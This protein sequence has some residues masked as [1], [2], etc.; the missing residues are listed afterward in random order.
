MTKPAADHIC[1]DADPLCAAQSRKHNRMIGH[2][3]KSHHA[4]ACLFQILIGRNSS[5]ARKTSTRPQFLAPGGSGKQA[6]KETQDHT[7]RDRQYRLRRRP[8]DELIR[9]SPPWTMRSTLTS[10]IPP[11]PRLPPLRPSFT[12]V[13]SSSSTWSLAR[14]C[15][16]LDRLRRDEV[17]QRTR[18]ALLKGCF[19][20]IALTFRFNTRV[21]RRRL[22]RNC[23]IAF[24]QA[25][26][27]WWGADR[28][29][30]I[31]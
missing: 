8:E 10:I 27:R 25:Q 17:C 24:P 1:L 26:R 22:I 3:A 31:V 2:L 29:R 21:R 6:S 30:W 12:C 15:Q 4:R 9:W 7:E 23:Q 11:S 13:K 19:Q 14:S 18:I 16:D 20:L 28:L 5:R